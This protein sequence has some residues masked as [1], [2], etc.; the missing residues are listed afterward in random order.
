MRPKLNLFLLVLFSFQISSCTNYSSFDNAVASYD[1]GSYMNAAEELNTLISKD[2]TVALYYQYRGMSYYQVNDYEKATADFLKVLDFYPKDTY[3]L[4]M[5]AS[6]Y[7]K[8]KQYKNA[9][10]YY[11]MVI[12]IDSAS[13]AAY[14]NRAFIRNMLGEKSKSIDDY[15]K[16]VILNPEFVDGLKSRAI[17]NA[18]LQNYQ[19][20]MADCQTLLK[21][22]IP[23]EEVLV[24]IGF[25]EELKGNNEIALK[26]YDSALVLNNQYFDGYNRRAIL[27]TKIGNTRSAYFDNIKAVHLNPKSAEALYYS[28]VISISNGYY[29]DGIRDFDKSIKIDPFNEKAYDGRGAAKLLLNDYEGAIH[30][31]SEA[32]KLNS[33]DPEAYYLRGQAK[34]KLND[35]NGCCSDLHISAALGFSAAKELLNKFHCDKYV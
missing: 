22:Q 31:F 12:D 14:S 32:I 26:F 7:A 5:I 13:F 16:A 11:S 20:A 4:L 23:K 10:L 2:S 18:E 27:K 3:L 21:K 30:D 1:K 6:N 8:L 25:I 33:K 17:I 28:G 29:A 19:Y 15:N 9:E 34:E 24:L 35:Y